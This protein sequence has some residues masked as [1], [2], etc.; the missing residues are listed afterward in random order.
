MSVLIDGREIECQLGKVKEFVAK[1]IPT[2]DP[3]PAFI[4]ESL[5]IGSKHHA[6]DLGKL[7]RLGI[8]ALLNCAPSGIRALPCEAYQ[9]H[10][11]LYRFTNVR[12]DSDDYPVLHG[13]DGVRSEH[14]DTAKAFYEDVQATGGKVL[15]FCVAGQNRSACLAVAVL[16]TTG[17]P[18]LEVLARCS[19][20]RPWVLENVGFQRQLC[21]LEQMRRFDR[22]D[23]ERP[24]FKRLCRAVEAAEEGHRVHVPGLYK[25]F[26]I[27]VASK[28]ASIAE[29]KSQV[30]QAVNQH[31]KSEMDAQV[32][33]SWLIYH[34]FAPSF[35]SQ[36]GSIARCCDL[37][38]EEEALE[39]GQ[40]LAWLEQAFSLHIED[41]KVAWK[42]CSCFE[43]VIFS[44]LPKGEASFSAPGLT[45]NV[46]PEPFEFSHRER[47][48]A[49]GTLLEQNLITTRLRAWDFGS[50]EAFRSK[51]GVVFSYVKDARNKKDFKEVSSTGPLQCQ[52]FSMPGADSDGAMLGMGANAIVQRVQLLPSTCA[53]LRPKG[54]FLDSAWTL[55]PPCS[56]IT[57]SGIM[58]EN[59]HHVDFSPAVVWDAAVKRSFGL[60]KMLASLEARSEAGMAKRLRMA[61]A[62]NKNGRLLYFYGLGL[63]LSSNAENRDQYRFETVLLSRYQEEFATYTLKKF[64]EDYTMDLNAGLV[65]A[66]RVLELQRLQ[67]EFSLIKV[68]VLLV[69]LL[70]GFRD[71]TLMGVQAFDFNHLNNVLISR[72]YK[73]ARLIDI[74]GDSKGSIQFPSEY[75]QGK[76]AAPDSANGVEELHMPALDVELSTVLPSVVSQ[77]ILGKGR[78]TSLV[79]NTTNE[80]SRAR[81]DQEAKTILKAVI[82]DNFFARGHRE[83][84]SEAA[85]KHLS[86]VV[87]WY[88]ALLKRRPPWSHWTKDIYDAMRCIDHLPI[89]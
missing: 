9:R 15:F 16:M 77:L 63:A 5:L 49:P 60:R 36:R 20:V 23:D 39:L 58:Q 12:R 64:L 88:F 2:E 3:D 70:N 52:K 75:I 68:K 8:T 24:K 17:E 65:D 4:A 78:G 40:Q 81:T 13:S 27:Q 33:K 31:L 62:L 43:L 32:G 69:S 25:S 37:V 50:G 26:R 47:P 30:L 67:S 82:R 44:L 85:E 38:L 55:N 76:S 72:D 21:Q 66:S 35:T 53:N 89:S 61:S 51:Q 71:L 6:A 22:H 73:K 84:L 1:A 41:G 54:Q 28:A 42:Q 11:I 14:L 18:L 83:D 74:D 87:E 56:S 19:T 45:G 7:L 48:N 46:V 79:A 29:V 59:H 80:V 86:K 10:G 34:G 57:P